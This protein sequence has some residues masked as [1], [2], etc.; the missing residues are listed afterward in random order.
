V[1]AAVCACKV[2]T[3]PNLPVAIEVIL[4]DSAR[5]EVTD[6]FRPSGQVLNGVGASLPDS[7]FWTSFDT[8]LRVVDSATGVSFG[9]SVGIG[10]LQARTGNLYSN[11][12]NVSVIP[13]LDSM[14]YADSTRQTLDFTPTDSTTDSLSDPLKIK[15]FATGGS[16]SSRRVIFLPTTYPDSAAPVTLLPR[17]TVATFGDGTASVQV[18]LHPGALPDSVVV[19][20]RMVKFHGDALPGSPVTF[21]VEIKP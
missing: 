14:T 17:D 3:N 5:V 10:R 1:L 13:R 12:Q 15:T 8:T 20:A 4:P 6:T 18:R 7:L 11:P 16:A 2:N 9:A 19:T 21:V